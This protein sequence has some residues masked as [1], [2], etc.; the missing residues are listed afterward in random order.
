MSKNNKEDSGIQWLI[1]TANNRHLGPYSTQ[2]ILKLI[3][4]GTFSGEEQIKRHPDGKW[5]PISKQPDFYDKLLEALD[6]V[7]KPVSKN[8][9]EVAQVEDPENTVIATLP[10]KFSNVPEIVEETVILESRNILQK[11][12]SFESSESANPNSVTGFHG[13]NTQTI[14]LTRIDHLVKKQKAKSAKVPLILIT[15]SLLIG[16]IGYFWPEGNSGTSK[17]GNLLVP[18]VGTSATLSGNDIKVGI[19]KAVGEFV[20]DTYENYEEAQNKLVAVIE[21]APQNIE[22][23]GTLCLVYKQLWPYVKQDSKDLDAVAQMTKATRSLDPTGISGVYCEIT[24]LMTQGKYK[25]AR[26]I[27]EYALNQPAMS[28]APVLYALKAE[29]LFEERETKTAVLYAD[30]AVQ[31]WPEWVLPQFNKGMY[32]ARIEQNSDATQALQNTLALNPKHKLAQIEYGILLF[33]GYRQNDEAIRLLTVAV[34]A[35]GKL[36]KLDQARANFYLALIYADKKNVSKAREYAQSAF[37]LNPGDPN[38]KDLLV[39]LGGNV[40]DKGNAGKNSEL[41][42][43]GDQHFRTGNCLAAQAEY[44]AA[45]ELDNTNAVAAM[46]AAKCLWQMSQGSEAIIWLNKAIKADP[47]LTTAYVLQADYYSERYNYASAVEVL[48]RASK[49]FPNNNE[50]LRGYGMVE[51]RRNNIKDA[52]G[53]LQRSYKAY[54]NDLENLILLAKA[55]AANRD[56]SSAQKY[57]VRAIELDAT[58]NE[59]QIVYAQILTQFQGLDT[60]LVYLKDLINKFSY[61]IEFRLALAD[62]YRAQEKHNIAQK[63]YEQ[64]VD[65]D[66]RNKKAHLGLGESYQAQAM[67]DK[68]LKEYLAATVIDPSDAEGLFRAGL[69]Y[70]DIGKYNE[71]ITQFK[72]ALVVNNLFPRLNY[73]IG[74][75]FFQ[76]GE[77]DNALISAHEERKINP[78]IA[79]SYLLSAEV[80][81]ATK[82]FQK[83]AGE[84]QL[85][86]KLRPQGADLYVKLDPAL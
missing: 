76:N 26:G 18:K 41:V 60:G 33:R 42:F 69:L 40:D 63:V 61:T 10:D 85:A 37:R 82:Q 52:L 44:K 28:T 9:D 49:I 55:S 75:A 67:F 51:F 73:Y 79:D 71:A 4:D 22:A 56:F 48:N 70:L 66:P 68:A 50:I 11:K 8:R 29:L 86:I 38:I 83:C 54:E 30:K 5:N 84:Y 27:V 17:K 58:N 43:L 2:S 78:N 32:L 53:F 35:Q 59:A 34:S 72:R 62:L 24:R 16:A 64:I 6:E 46:K 3:S 47:K 19:Q 7:K 74:R 1:K 77:Y 23:R 21:G 15:A 12:S 13:V 14:D 39:R 65:A 36:A 45:F 25:E 81:T 57:A 31:L 20:K 80:Y